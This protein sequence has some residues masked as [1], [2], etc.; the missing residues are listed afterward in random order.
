MDKVGGTATTYTG[1]TGLT[2]GNTAAYTDATANSKANNPAKDQLIQQ[3]AE[4]QGQSSQAE[5]GTIP[6]PPFDLSTGNVGYGQGTL[7][8]A[9]D[10]LSS[11]EKEL[12]GIDPSSPEGSKK[13]TL[14]NIKMQRVQQ[15]IG[16][17]TEI[18]KN[19]HDLNMRIIGN[20]R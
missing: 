9:F 16:L 14:I 6:E 1:P 4:Q 10:A 5:R 20:M 19:I 15:V 7:D 17:I 12:E 18:R 3:K 11:L 8:R 2:T 13:M